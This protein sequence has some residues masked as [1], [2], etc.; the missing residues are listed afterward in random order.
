MISTNDISIGWAGCECKICIKYMFT[1]ASALFNV[2]AV[3]EATSHVGYQRILELA[4]LI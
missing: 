1:F 3:A 4:F 2:N